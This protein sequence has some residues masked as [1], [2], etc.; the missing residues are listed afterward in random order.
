MASSSDVLTGCCIFYY[1]VLFATFQQAVVVSDT[2][3]ILD[4]WISPFSLFYYVLWA[5]VGFASV[6]SFLGFNKFRK[7]TSGDLSKRALFILFDAVIVGGSIL[8]DTVIMMEA[9]V[10]LLFIPRFGMVL[11]L[12]LMY[13]SFR[14]SK[15]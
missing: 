13:W 14:P 15:A 8:L 7:A 3:V 1:I 11:G 10:N 4:D 12:F 5:L 6:I 9:E 2:G